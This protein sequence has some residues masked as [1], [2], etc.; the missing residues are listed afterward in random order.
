MRVGAVEYVNLVQ[1]AGPA[2]GAIVS[3]PLLAKLFSKGDHRDFAGRSLEF[4]E[5]QTYCKMFEIFYFVL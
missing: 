5:H 4:D 1:S 2:A 3:Q